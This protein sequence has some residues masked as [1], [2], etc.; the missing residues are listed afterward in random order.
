MA[1]VTLNV[2]G[3]DKEYCTLADYQKSLLADYRKDWLYA[4]LEAD[5]RAI[6]EKARPYTMTCP[7]RMIS[8]IRAVKYV[9]NNNIPGDFVECGVWKGGSVMIIALTLMETGR[10]DRKIYLYDTFEGM[11]Q[12]GREDIDVYGSSAIPMF[13]STYD[14]KEKASN[15]MCSRLHEVRSNV[16]QTNYPESN[17]VFISG[18]VEDTIPRVLPES[19]AILRLDTDWYESTYHELVHLFPLVSRRGMLIVDDFG[20][21]EGAKL[22]VRRYFDENH[23]DMFLN[24]VD[25]TCR[26]G[27][28]L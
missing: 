1:E 23:I 9:I 7:E 19:I 27:Q 13:D 15:W 20:H 8:L 4:D 12:P 14:S 5:E 26:M 3:E 22:A 28:K 21:W 2:A 6:I 18:K 16:Y 25:Y 11:T 24:R 10:R 17:F